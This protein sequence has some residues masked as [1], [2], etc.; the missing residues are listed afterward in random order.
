MPPA[1]MVFPMHL[2]QWGFEVGRNLP[3]QQPQA[4]DRAS[5]QDPLSILGDEDQMNMPSRNTM[6]ATIEFFTDP[7][8]PNILRPC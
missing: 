6:L 1:M 5:V 2:R 8:G 4:V 3:Q 7:H